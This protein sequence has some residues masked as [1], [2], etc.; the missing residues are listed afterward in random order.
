MVLRLGPIEA[1]IRR[2]LR[3]RFITQQKKRR[4]LCKKLIKLGVEKKSVMK[5]VYSKH[6][7]WKLSH[8][9]AVEQAFSNDWFI[10]KIKEK[11][12]SNL[13]LPDWFIVGRYVKLT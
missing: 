12:Y 5:T 9:R 4:H 8:T 10:R 3:A 2:R 7:T 6:N 11:I 1:H 13:M